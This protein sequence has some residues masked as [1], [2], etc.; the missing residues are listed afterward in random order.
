MRINSKGS[1]PLNQADFILTLASVFWDEGRSQLETS[2]EDAKIPSAGG[3]SPFNHLA[4][5]PSRAMLRVSAVG[6]VFQTSTAPVHVIPILR[7]KDLK[8]K[9]SVKREE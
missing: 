7:G 3:P 5:N 4:S 2:S 9:L 8:Q 1:R 6:L